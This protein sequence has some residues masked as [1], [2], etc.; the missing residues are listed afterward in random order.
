MRH[1]RLAPLGVTIGLLG[2]LAVG[3]G[4]DPPTEVSSDV[5]ATVTLASGSPT[6]PA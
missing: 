3:C 5:T 6:P 2:F 4:G 1:H